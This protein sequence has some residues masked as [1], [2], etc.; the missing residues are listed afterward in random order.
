M[1]EAWEQLKEWTWIVSIRLQ[2]EKSCFNI[3][4]Y[5]FPEWNSKGKQQKSF[6]LAQNICILMWI[7]VVQYSEIQIALP[8]SLTQ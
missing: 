8:Q 7:S 5:F 4:I 6:G 1:D 2:E 3:V